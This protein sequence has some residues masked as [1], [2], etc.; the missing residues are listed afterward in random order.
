MDYF[1]ISA[2]DL[3][4][5]REKNVCKHA[6][7]INRDKLLELLVDKQLTT[8]GIVHLQVAGGEDGFDV[9]AAATKLTPRG[10]KGWLSDETRG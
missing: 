3:A 2:E 6:E 7:I 9:Y 4:V 5:S 1:K 8:D 10:D